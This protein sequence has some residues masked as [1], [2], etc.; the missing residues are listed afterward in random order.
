MDARRTALFSIGSAIAGA[1]ALAASMTPAPAQ[2]ADGVR[3]YGISMA[4]KNDCANAAGTHS[5]A[6]Q[7][8]DNYSGLDW[9]AVKDAA[10]CTAEKGKLEPFQ[11]MNP[12]KKA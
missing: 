5:C 4:G 1:V 10:A 2:A 7:T 9:K 8:K 11:G 3:C 12:E 6:G